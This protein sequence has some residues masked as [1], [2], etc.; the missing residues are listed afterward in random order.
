M[1]GRRNNI[2]IPERRDGRGW[3]NLVEVLRETSLAAG[4]MVFMT[5]AAQPP[6]LYLDV[7]KKPR[8]LDPS[9][10][11]V[12]QRGEAPLQSGDVVASIG[13]VGQSL[14]GAERE[15]VGLNKESLLR[16][17][18]EMQRQVEDLKAN[19]YVIKRCV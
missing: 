6:I 18:M 15:I 4:P 7:V 9:H 14:E 8:A 3:R 17:V 12:R 5:S 16:V 10:Q 13:V 19:L 2:L 1:G 11:L